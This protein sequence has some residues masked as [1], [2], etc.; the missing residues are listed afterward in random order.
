VV[1]NIKLFKVTSDSRTIRHFWRLMTLNYC[2]DR[3]VQS[4]RKDWYSDAPNVSHLVL[5]DAPNVSHLVLSRPMFLDLSVLTFLSSVSAFSLILP[6][7]Y[8]FALPI[9][10]CAAASALL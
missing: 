4:L 2:I 8:Q 10:G 3:D 6:N 1:N 5:S 7:F 9:T